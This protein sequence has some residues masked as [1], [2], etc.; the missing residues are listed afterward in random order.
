MPQIVGQLNTLLHI[1]AVLMALSIAF[2]LFDS[3]LFAW[4]PLFMSI[5]YLLF[6]TE[7]LL[8]AVMFR[9]LDGTE[10]VS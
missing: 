1:S 4:H 3:T 5:G 10:R 8:S 6:M 2:L 7:G 9:H